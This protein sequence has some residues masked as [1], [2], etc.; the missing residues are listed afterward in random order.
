MNQDSEFNRAIRFHFHDVDARQYASYS[1]Y[2]LDTLRDEAAALELTV[3]FA[4][5]QGLELTPS[6]S[7]YYSGI[8][9]TGWMLHRYLC[10]FHHHML[11]RSVGTVWHSLGLD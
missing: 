10:L 1:S 6:S 8:T 4:V 3:E 9:L 7:G 11:R 2:I 5:L